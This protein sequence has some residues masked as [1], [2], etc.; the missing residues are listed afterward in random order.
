[1]MLT[2]PP[3]P[4]L[5]PYVEALWAAD[6]D[7]SSPAEARRELVLPTGAVHLAI[8]V[9][10]APLR[11]F[12]AIEQPVGRDVAHALV[13]GARTSY[14]V[15]DVSRPA[16]TVGAM[17]RPGAAPLLLGEPAD[18]LAGRHTA[19]E[20]LWGSAALAA[21]ERLAEATTL[22]QRLDRF[23]ALLAARMPRLRGIHPAVAEA[24]ARFRF[25]SDVRGVV[26]CTGYSHR[27]FIELFREAVGLTPK[28]YCRVLR[29]HHAL[30]SA[31]SL[32]GSWAELALAAGYA[33]QAHFN[34]DFRQFA[35]VTPS[36]YRRL[37]PVH[38]HHV[39]IPE[40]QWTELSTTTRPTRATV[41]TKVRR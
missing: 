33:D 21:R 40:S 29:F 11:I 24:I 35:G 16:R 37:R 20:D 22:E 19:L 26:Q 5:R 7:G 13:G 4:A 10:D 25:T 34:R 30:E 39:P 1:M 6:A 12:D 27:R 36:R 32:A 8:R 28:L 14:Y 38:S 31:V 18:A 2:R 3:G 17:L 9:S 15:R 23:E 41:Q